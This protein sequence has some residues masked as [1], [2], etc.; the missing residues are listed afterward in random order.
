LSVPGDG[1][2]DLRTPK[3][4]SLGIRNVF[5]GLEAEVQIVE[6]LRTVAIRPTTDGDVRCG[7]RL[8]SLHRSLMICALWGANSTSRSKA[9]SSMLPTSTPVC[10]RSL[11]FSRLLER[12]RRF[13]SILGKGRSVVTAGPEPARPVAERKTFCQMPCRRSRMRESIPAMVERKV[14]PSMAVMPPF[15]PMPSRSVCS[16]GM[17]G[18]AP[19][20]PSTA[21]TACFP[22]LY[23]RCD[24]ECSPDEGSAQG[25]T[26]APLTHTVAE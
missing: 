10:G 13:E 21:R 3:L 1:V 16:C 20:R 9:M 18:V 8:C 25:A 11:T 4:M 6:I 12:P 7:A 17:P 26:C 2:T 24:V 5:P 19:A 15:F 14:G 22:G 23:L